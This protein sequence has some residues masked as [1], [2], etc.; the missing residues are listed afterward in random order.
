MT[1]NDP[2]NP[3]PLNP[4]GE[5]PGY[6]MT[7]PSNRNEW[8]GWLVGGVVLVLLIV[9]G[10]FM[11][12]RNDTTTASNPPRPAPTTTG[13]GTVPLPGSGQG[14][15]GDVKQAVPPPPR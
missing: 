8:L 4:R 10:L 6:P 15:S 11:M 7:R 12:N 14:T 9:S 13:S 2:V 3:D 5:R 1:Y